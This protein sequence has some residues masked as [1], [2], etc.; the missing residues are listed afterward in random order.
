[1]PDRYAVLGNPIAHSRSPWIHARF[2]ALTQQHLSYERELVP[3]DA[4]APTVR[5]LHAA[6]LRGCN[7]TVPFKFEAAALADSLTPEAALA[8]AAN[9]LHWHAGGLL[10]HNTDGLGL[11]AD[12]TQGAGLTLRGARVLLLGAGGAAAGVLGAL[13]RTQPACVVLVNRR[14]ERA[15]SLRQRHTELASLQKTELTTQA[16]QALAG[17]FDCIINATTAS[18]QG[19]PLQLDARWL[20]DGALVYDMM[21]GAAARPFLD[22]AA[23]LGA[24]TRDGLGM[25][26]QQAA[27]SFE[28]WRGVLPPAAAVLAE[29]RLLV[30]AT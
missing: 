6:G 28:L 22:G 27:A 12:L 11:V 9:T 2:A 7:V 13:L 25:L 3:L 15:E 17:S 18:L 16:Q 24:R 1:M 10:G 21:Y 14:A 26:V 29:L 23:A 5:A 4:F 20:R 8:Q 19:T 30:D